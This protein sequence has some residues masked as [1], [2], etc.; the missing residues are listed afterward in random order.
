LFFD[1]RCVE[2]FEFYRDVLGAEVISLMRF[3]DN[4]A[5]GEQGASTPANSPAC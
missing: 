5:P 3:K 4:P 1:G 2:A